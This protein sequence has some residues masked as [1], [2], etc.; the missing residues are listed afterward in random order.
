LASFPLPGKAD[1]IDVMDGERKQGADLVM[2]M[3]F[4]LI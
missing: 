3:G 2:V 4:D 1:S